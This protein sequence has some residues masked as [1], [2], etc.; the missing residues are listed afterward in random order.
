M[1][2]AC[3]VSGAALKLCTRV[4]EQ[5]GVRVYGTTGAWLGAVVDNSAIGARTYRDTNVH[6]CAL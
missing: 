1:H 5:H 3:D 2:G 6:R 4:Y